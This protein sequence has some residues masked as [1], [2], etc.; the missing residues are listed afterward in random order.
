MKRV[1]GGALSPL[2]HEHLKVG[3]AI[4]VKKPEGR[5][6]LDK[7]DG[8]VLLFA[9]GSGITPVIAILKTALASTPRRV[10]LL[11]ANRNRAS[12]IFRDE[13]RGA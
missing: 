5:F 2:L 8:P 12:I 10:R 1:A 4:D 6:V 3:N 9:G 11:Y 13:V 7:A